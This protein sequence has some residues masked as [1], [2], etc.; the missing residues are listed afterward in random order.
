MINV[1]KTKITSQK[2]KSI[3]VI[4]A[5]VTFITGCTNEAG[6]TNKANIGTVT[7]LVLGGAAGSA[8]GS[9]KGKM[10]AIAAGATLGSLAGREFG[11]SLDRADLGYQNKTFNSAMEN[12]KSGVISSWR[13][14]DSGNAGA[15]I[16]NRTYVNNNGQNCR[17]YTQT[18]KI[19]GKVQEGFGK[20]CRRSDGSWE[21]IS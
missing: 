8:F 12:N 14:P 4:L 21:I 6:H 5:A 16:P 19:G 13:N 7:G 11:S 18:I 10:L 20:A 1:E 9:G 15:V 3:V 17:E 2:I